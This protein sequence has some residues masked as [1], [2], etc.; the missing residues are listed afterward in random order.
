MTIILKEITI[1]NFVDAI[2]LEVKEEQRNFVASNAT[3]IAQSKFQA[4]LECYGIYDGE[5]MVGFSAFGKN[6]K[7][8]TIWLVRHMVDKNFQ[9]KGYGKSGL[10]AVIKHLKNKYS[11][12]EIY[13]DV[14]EDNEIAT[15]LYVKT[16]FKLTGKKNE[17]SPIY[18]LDLAEYAE[19]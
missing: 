9:G 12:S 15:S 8:D 18:K 14:A 1:E 7:D 19:D 17:H 13:L 10:K 2:K 4:F 5:K 11:C 6:P 16:G 3:S